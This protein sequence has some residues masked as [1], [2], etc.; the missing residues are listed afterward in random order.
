[1]PISIYFVV[2]GGA[3]PPDRTGYTPSISISLNPSIRLQ[4][5]IILIHSSFPLGILPS[6]PG[7]LTSLRA[8]KPLLKA[9]RSEPDGD[10]WKN[11]KGVS[12]GG[13]RVGNDNRGPSTLTTEPSFPTFA[14]SEFTS[15]ILLPL[16]SLHLLKANSLTTLPPCPKPNR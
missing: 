14:V 13:E 12:H 16:P 1:M 7:I 4:N 10:R 6:C 8:V 5:S 11:K 2:V 9:L 3:G 15:L